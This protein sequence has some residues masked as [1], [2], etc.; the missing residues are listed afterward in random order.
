M[1]TAAPPARFAAADLHRLAEGLCAAAGLEPPKAAVMAEVLVEADLLGH[2][3]HGLALLPRYLGDIESGAMKRDGAPEVI[4][5]RGAT[6]AWRGLRLPGPWLVRQAVDLAIER[7]ATYGSCTVAI[8][9]AHHIACLAAYLTRATDRGMMLILTTSAPAVAT[10]APFGARQPVLTPDPIAVGIPTPGEPILIDISASIT[11]N[12]MAQTLAREGRRYPHPWLLDAAGAPTDDPNALFAGGALLP[13]GGL[14]HGQKG[15]GWA[16]LAEAMTQ[17]LSGFGRADQPK[18]LCGAV[19]VQVLDP[20]AFGG[21]EAFI[22]QTGFTAEA[23]RAA[24]PLPGVA[25]VRLPGEA[26]LAHR[27]AALA[28]GVPLSASITAGLRE[29]CARLGPIMPDAI[30]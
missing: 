14:D 12:N 24:A 9:D 29:A 13:A 25:R 30:A 19:C 7:A 11:T 21:R 22:R 4:R 5:D 28:C 3:T 18:G 10:V 1:T 16:L 6:L 20:D 17:G 8:G 2:A 15:Y 27:R 26:A 23:C